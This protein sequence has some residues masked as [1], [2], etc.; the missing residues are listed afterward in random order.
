[1][2]WVEY[3]APQKAY[4]QVNRVVAGETWLLSECRIPK[5]HDLW[6]L[7]ITLSFPSASPSVS[8]CYITGSWVACRRVPSCLT[9]NSYVKKIPEVPI[10]LFMGHMFSFIFAWP[11]H[12]NLKTKVFKFPK[13]S[14]YLLHCC[15][16]SVNTCPCVIRF[17]KIIRDIIKLKITGRSTHNWLS[18]YSLLTAFHSWFS[19][20]ISFLILVFSSLLALL[21]TLSFSLS[22]DSTEGWIVSNAS[23][24]A[25]NETQNIYVINRFPKLFQI[26]NF[27]CARL[28]GTEW[29]TTS[30]GYWAWDKTS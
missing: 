9:Q 28:F 29:T 16:Q 13:H 6:P 14:K 18:E 17:I 7:P 3:R 27:H 19:F 22:A 11:I 2:F 20:S 8:S 24:I 5:D 15:V 23:L 10:I 1:M 25:W 4:S 12:T 21:S 30:L 26:N